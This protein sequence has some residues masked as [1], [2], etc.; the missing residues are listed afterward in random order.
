MIGANDPRVGVQ[1]W[2]VPTTVLPLVTITKISDLWYQILTW[3]PRSVVHARHCA[4]LQ[5]CTAQWLQ[6]RKPMS[7]LEVMILL[8]TLQCVLFTF[9][10]HWAADTYAPFAS[11]ERTPFSEAACAHLW[12]QQLHVSC[13]SESPTG[14]FRWL[15]SVHKPHFTCDR[16][17][18][19]PSRKRWKEGE[20][21]AQKVP[22]S[23][24]PWL[25]IWCGNVGHVK[26]P[27]PK[28]FD[29]DLAPTFLL[30]QQTSG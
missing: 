28:R 2:N 13:E 5:L 7:P 26:W 18:A 19:N 16:R 30:E 15:I 24:R 1:G 6:W 22:S 27:W 8:C 29:C 17:A 23:E 10:A 21:A 3:F 4:E 14:R 9:R 20:P 25:E 12:W 11:W